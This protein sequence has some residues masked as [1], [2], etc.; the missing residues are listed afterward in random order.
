MSAQREIRVSD[1]ERQGAVDR[2]H[3][4]Q[5]EGRLDLVE[6]DRR[7]L[8]AYQAV[9]YRDLD[10]LFVDLP[11]TAVSPAPTVQSERRQA[12]EEGA[13]RWLARPLPVPDL[14]LILKIL[15]ANWVAVVVINVTVWLLVN[16]GSDAP[17]YFWP[18]WLT[19]PGVVL[20]GASA[21]VNAIRNSRSAHPAIGPGTPT[22]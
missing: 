6:Y 15:W 8:L 10:Q 13:S 14:P 3:A 21:G 1:G 5:D 2:L 16:V 19:V 7:L 17:G 18:V 22:R 11:T 4:A 9:T 20:L 12:V